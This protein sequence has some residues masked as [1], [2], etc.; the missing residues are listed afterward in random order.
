MSSYCSQC[1]TGLQAGASFCPACGRAVPKVGAFGQVPTPSPS[2]A[3]PPPRQLDIPMG[4]SY[5]G[6]SSRQ[7]Q[8]S[9]F[10]WMVLPLQRYADFSG[11]S[12]RQEYWMF[13]LLNSIVTVIALIFIIAGVPWSDI[14]NDVPGATPNAAL[15]VGLAILVIWGLATFIPNIAVTVRRLHDQNLT[16]WLFL[17]FFAADLILGMGWM[18]RIIFMCFDG[19]PGPNQ[20]GP[21]PKGRGVDEVF[22]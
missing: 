7:P 18:A 5:G 13:Y 2:A 6:Y 20:Y 1:G 9:A 14:F 22:A 12:Q 4:H 3:P 21:D 19:T 10:D 15:W 8:R 16:G 17:A 11:R